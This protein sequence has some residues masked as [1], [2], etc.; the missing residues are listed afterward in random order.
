MSWG[1]LWGYFFS[2]H[3][4]KGRASRALLRQDEVELRGA[5]QAYLRRQH[6]RADALFFSR[7]L[8]WTGLQTDLDE[9]AFLV[10]L[11]FLVVGDAALEVDW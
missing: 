9:L 3:P 11:G 2:S 10:R 7:D 8:E 5:P 6:L 4:T 1:Y